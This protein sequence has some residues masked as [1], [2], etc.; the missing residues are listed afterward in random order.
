MEDISAFTVNGIFKFSPKIMRPLLTIYAKKNNIYRPIENE[1]DNVYSKFLLM[2]SSKKYLIFSSA[3][4]L[5]IWLMRSPKNF[6]KIDILNI[7][8]LV[9]LSGV[10]THFGKK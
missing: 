9:F 7:L 4:Y 1:R 2:K 5:I 8:Q 3:C 10:K 6:G